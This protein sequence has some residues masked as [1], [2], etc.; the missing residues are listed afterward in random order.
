MCLT[1]QSAKF[2]SKNVLVD[3]LTVVLLYYLNYVIPIN[4]LA[5]NNFHSLSHLHRVVA[6]PIPERPYHKV[7]A[8]VRARAR[9]C[10]ISR[11]EVH[12]ITRSEISV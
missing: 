1:I 2:F 7:C 12:K 10:G 11:Q 4:T 3:I 6:I 8:C 5:Y 9:V